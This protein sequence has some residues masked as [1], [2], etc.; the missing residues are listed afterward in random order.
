MET[1][2]F[3]NRL[4]AV[5]YKRGLKYS[6]MPETVLCFILPVA[7][8]AKTFLDVGAG[9]GTLALPLAR[10]GKK[11]TA[12]DPSPAMLDILKEDIRKEGLKNI[13]T[14]LAAWGEVSLKP[15]DVII[16]ANVPELLKGSM[17]F[18]KEANA[19]A[20]K[21]VFFI[22]NADPKADK[23]Y[24]RELFPL[25]FSKPFTEKTDYLKTYTDLHSLG[26]FANVKIIEYDFDQPL[27]DLDEAVEFWKE[28]MGLVTE[29]HDVKLKEFLGKK[30]KKTRGGLIAK[31][32]KKSAIIWWMKDGVRRKSKGGIS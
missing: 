11:V 2:G 31:F 21:S 17:E 22:E 12:L 15:H 30:L 4:K 7:G 24:Y 29:E 10:A 3:W 32:H 1:K 28:Y 26:I 20:R 6:K 27:K 16:C 5:W 8:N 13:K 9:C 19:L 14:V 23:F 25:I 18:L